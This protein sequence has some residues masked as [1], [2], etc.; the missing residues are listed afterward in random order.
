MSKLKLADM[1]MIVFGAG[2]AGTGIADQIRDAIVAENGKPQKEASRQIWCIDKPGLLLKSHG[3][4]LTQAQHN[5]AREDSEWVGK[6]H[7]DLLS[8]VKEVKPH[9]LIG[10]STKPKAFTEQVIKEMAKHVDRPIVLPLSNPTRLHEADPKDINNW[11]EGKA[12]IA[13]GSPF[14]PVRYNGKEYEIAECNNSAVFPGIGLGAVL[15]RSKLLSDKMLVAAVR[16]LADQSPAMQDPDKALLPDVKDVRELSVHIAKAVVRTAV[17][18]DLAME[19][20]IPSDDAN[21]EEWVREQMW[22]PRYRP[23]VRP[24]K[25]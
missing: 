5:Y 8:V 18:E 6:K 15:S 14:P 17:E 21:L 2:T 3:D 16:A 4:K 24:K 22:Q 13:T 7:D 25:S 9:V 10:T 11:T 23:L 12:L 1:R 20:D 19:K